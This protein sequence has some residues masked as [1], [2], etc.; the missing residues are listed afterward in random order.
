MYV[1][2]SH[3]CSLVATAIR[4]IYTYYRTYKQLFSYR[5]FV[6]GSLLLFTI[7]DFKIHE[8]TINRVIRRIT[9][10]NRRITRNRRHRHRVHEFRA[11]S[12]KTKMFRTY[13]YTLKNKRGAK[14]D[15]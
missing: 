8:E 4:D 13:V 7:L 15:N 2:C 6:N 14:T 10:C 11:D 1:G 9:I 12:K 5:F 3:V